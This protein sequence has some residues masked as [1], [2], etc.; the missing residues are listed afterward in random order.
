MP[1]KKKEAK[2]PAEKKTTTKKAEAKKAPAQTTAAAA[3]KN[4]TK[5]QIVAHFAEKFKLTKDTAGGILDEFAALSVS[6]TKRTGAF[7][8]PGLG[9][10]TLK[11]REARMGRNPATGET[12]KIPAKTVV[13]MRLSKTLTDAIVPAKKKAK[14]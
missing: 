2:K 1:V 9:K 3:A 7:T 11:K 13:K 8:I 4:M 12:I 6:E 10:L 5:T 14:K